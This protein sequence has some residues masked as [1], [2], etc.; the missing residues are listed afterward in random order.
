MPGCTANT[1][2]KEDI[3]EIGLGL[4]NHVEQAE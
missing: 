4:L 1:S 3:A 2:I